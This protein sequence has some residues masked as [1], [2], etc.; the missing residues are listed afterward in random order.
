MTHPIFDVLVDAARPQ[1]TDFRNFIE[2]RLPL[3]L[4]DA[5][6][7]TTLDLPGTPTVSLIGQL[8]EFDA[9]DTTSAHNGSSVLVSRDG[10]RYK[11]AIDKLKLDGIAIGATANDTDANLKARANHT[12][13]LPASVRF[14]AQS[15]AEGGELRLEK[16]A[17]G[18]TFGG[19]VVLDLYIDSLRMFEQ[20]GA[21]RGAI[22]DFT[23]QPPGIIARI[24]TTADGAP[25]SILEFIDSALHTNILNG[26][27]AGD[28]WAAFDSALD[29]GEDI[30]LPRAGLATIT[31][32]LDF[33]RQGQR[34][35]GASAT[36]EGGFRLY[37]DAGFNLAAP[38][39][40]GGAPYSH[41][42][43]VFI[44]F[45]Q[46]SSATSKAAL[47][48]Y[49]WAMSARAAQ[50]STWKNVGWGGAWN[51]FD[52]RGTDTVNHPGGALIDGVLDGALNIGGQFQDI[53]DFIK[54]DHWHGW[55]FGYT[56]LTNVRQ[57]NY[58]E[59]KYLIFGQNIEALSVGSLALWMMTLNSQ[60]GSIFK[61][62][63]QSV[64]LDGWASLLEWQAGDGLIGM[65]DILCD[66]NTDHHLIDVQGGDCAVGILNI[67]DANAHNGEM[68]RC[69]A[70]RFSAAGG[71]IMSTGNGWHSQAAGGVISLANVQ[72]VTGGNTVR[73]LPFHKQYGATGKLILTGCEPDAIG[74]GA[75]I[76]A[77]CEGQ[78]GNRITNNDFGGYRLQ[79]V[80]AMSN[81]F[82]NNIN[83]GSEF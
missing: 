78:T 55:E 12:G 63:F 50:R 18:T 42:E 23:R 54:I 3:V 40:L 2:E 51:G 22:L 41:V 69:T 33:V 75:G 48:Q 32:R 46:P 8:F 13:D 67:R 64:K 61:K 66:K 44:R 80:S 24:R 14:A 30:L 71:K 52:G 9:A 39:V 83:V 58:S 10:R 11:A 72:S 15:G 77:V 5:A 62:S 4:A 68:I 37:C 36:V 76:F 49:P 17:S 6:E 19:D 16:P 74:T 29:S 47:R 38:H 70:G 25:R 57:I 79:A 21:A 20:G 45:D 7:I 65:L 81:L 56:H 27:H 60:G 1:K 53:Y 43:N 35:F 73:T 82:S 28:L 59:P 34:M 31:D 26:T